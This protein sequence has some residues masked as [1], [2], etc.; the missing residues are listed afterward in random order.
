MLQ[1]ELLLLHAAGLNDVIKEE[2]A[3]G[4]IIKP[5]AMVSTSQTNRP[6]P[7]TSWSTGSARLDPWLRSIDTDHAWRVHG[8]P[9]FDPRPEHLNGGKGNYPLW[10]SCLTRPAFRTL[11]RDWE[12]GA[13][14]FPALGDTSSPSQEARAGTCILTRR[15]HGR[16][17]RRELM[18]VPAIP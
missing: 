15:E 9:R 16:G 13:Q 5:T 4:G 7:R 1:A 18:S 11:F 17:R 6:P 3:A 8:R 14:Q 10:E 2:L 12:N